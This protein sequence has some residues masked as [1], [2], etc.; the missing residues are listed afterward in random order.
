MS[1]GFILYK[2]RHAISTQQNSKFSSEQYAL[3]LNFLEDPQ[4][5]AK[6]WGVPGK[7]DV[8]VAP[9]RK[10]EDWKELATIINSRFRSKFNLDMADCWRTYMNKYTAA[11]EKSSSTGF[12][13]TDEDKKRNIHTVQAKLDMIC[14]HYERMQALVSER[15]NVTRAA[16]FDSGN[17]TSETDLNEL[18]SF[19]AEKAPNF[20]NDDALTATEDSS[21]PQDIAPH[22]NENP[23]IPNALVLSNEEVILRPPSQ[24]YQASAYPKLEDDSIYT[25]DLD[26]SPML[27]A[28]TKRQVKMDNTNTNKSKK[29]RRKE[30]PSL[31]GT[32]TPTHAR[33]I[34]AQTIQESTIAKAV[35]LATVEEK[36][37]KFE[38]IKWETER[39]DSEVRRKEEVEAERKIRAEDNAE[40]CSERR[41]ALLQTMIA[42]GK[43][44]DEIVNIISMPL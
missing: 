16:I 18:L 29:D 9:P 40:K 33:S 19:I 25:G 37:L 1:T 30:M 11:R 38:Q 13:V 36:K 41:F 3:I 20:L 23:V 7:T 5:K 43:P 15:A 6:I 28:G 27:A 2:L 39:A 12:G 35:V 22:A 21:E 10:I 26:V 24:H 17:I 42:Q 44:E 32:K 8:G 31:S 14:P 34:L 4:N